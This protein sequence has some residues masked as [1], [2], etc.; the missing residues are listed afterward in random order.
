MNR[1]YREM[2]RL[3]TFE[4][5]LDYLRLPGMV[6]EQTFGFDRWM[7]QRFYHSLEW[8]QVRQYVL[9]R[10]QGCDLGVA[11]F[12]IGLSPLVHHINP[13]N[14]DDI[15]EADDTLLDPDN[16]ITTSHQTHNAIH[17]GAKV[18]AVPTLPDRKPGDTKLW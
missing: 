17:Y 11:G 8:D 16:L 3:E 1:S 9:V 13:I 7:N 5:R 10:D 18:L 4:D 12:E 6:G 14:V 15:I 2:S